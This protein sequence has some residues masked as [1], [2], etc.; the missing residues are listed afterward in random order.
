MS[1]IK[2]DEY[3]DGEQIIRTVLIR[4][5]HLQWQ[6][7]RYSSGLRTASDTLHDESAIREALWNRLTAKGVN[8]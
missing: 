3:N 7:A 1:Q 5:E 6:L 8:A 2:I 4:E